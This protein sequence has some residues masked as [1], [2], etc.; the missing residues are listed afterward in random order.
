MEATD[1]SMAEGLQLVKVLACVLQRLVAA[2]DRSTAGGPGMAVTKFHALRPP[3]IGIR[4]YLERILRYAS[5]SN[6]CFVL[7][8]VYIDR[9]I[10]RNNFV[11]SSLNVHRIIITSVMLAAK[12]F[13]DQYFNNAYYAK[14]GGVPTVELNAL[15][16]EFLFSINFALHVPP[17]VFTRYE[18]ELQNHMHSAVP[19]DCTPAPGVH[20]GFPSAPAGSDGAGG[21][22][23]AAFS[24]AAPAAAPSASHDAE[25]GEDGTSGPAHS[26]FGAPSASSAMAAPPAPSAGVASPGHDAGM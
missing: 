3:S 23:G 14:V 13:D 25:M 16:L 21:A 2:N 12:F 5:C 9:L 11:L 22:G 17:D 19:C 10:Q 1:E 6:Q 24:S 26:G 15:E 7:S 4:D 20:V 18:G 8:L